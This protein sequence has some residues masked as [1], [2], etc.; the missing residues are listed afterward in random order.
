MVHHRDS[1]KT[2]SFGDL[3][4]K[5]ATLPLPNPKTVALKEREALLGKTHEEQEQLLARARREIASETEAVK[6]EKISK[7]P[8][9][10]QRSA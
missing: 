9:L 6:N 5:A 4:A 1:G 2:L 10:P 3:A 7:L 8:K